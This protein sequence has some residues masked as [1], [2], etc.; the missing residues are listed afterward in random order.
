MSVVSSRHEAIVLRRTNYGEADRIVQFL[1]PEGKISA[2]AR[3]VRKEKSK[4]AGGIELLATTDIILHRGRGNLAIVT[5]ARLDQFFMHILGDYDRLQFAYFVLKDISRAAEQIEDPEFFA[6][7]RIVLESLDV[8][9]ISIGTIEFWYRLQ[10]ASLMGASANLTR[11]TA[12]DKLALEGK[13]RFDTT[14]MAFAPHPS[15]EYTSDHIKLLR[16]AQTNPPSLVSHISGL[17]EL[18]PMCLVVARAVHE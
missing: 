13:Y 4:L 5:S 15:G 8:A 16:V 2:L 18:L 10:M 14:E 7:T 12:G 6:I 1:T 11:D 9:V 17:T 3:G